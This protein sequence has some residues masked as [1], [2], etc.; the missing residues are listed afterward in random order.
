MFFTIRRQ[1]SHQCQGQDCVSDRSEDTFAATLL[2]M[3]P[4]SPRE[5]FSDC[6]WL[7]IPRHR[8]ALIVEESVQPPGRLLGG[9]TKPP[10]MSKLAALAAKRRQQESQKTSSEDPDQA[11]SGV[12]YN[13]TLK[14]LQIS[15]PAKQTQ[16]SK[17]NEELSE[18]K[19]VD[20]EA[21][22]VSLADVP[23]EQLN[24]AQDL[25][26]TPSTFG[27]LLFHTTKPGHA[28]VRLNET[29]NA[30]FDFSQ[31]S[32]DDVISKAQRGR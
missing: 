28:A 30:K 23:E 16:S 3:P 8:Q 10:K 19:Q 17:T 15:R 1:A 20:L 18:G 14:K 27:S 5:F 2:I 26:G 11:V 13:E 32:P 31:P 12:E 22:D 9:S 7:N 24:T 25:R 21:Q 6:P 29:R 4:S